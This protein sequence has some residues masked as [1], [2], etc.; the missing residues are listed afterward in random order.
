MT[1]TFQLPPEIFSE[2]DA[3]LFDAFVAP[4][5]LRFY[6]E[7]VQ[8]VLLVGQAAR[9]VHLGCRTGYPDG[10][11]L[12]LMPNTTGVGVDH[13]TNLLQLARGKQLGPGVEYLEGNSFQTGLPAA[14]FSHALSLHPLGGVQGRLYLFSEMARLLYAGG[15]AIV[16]LPLGR[17]FQE[18]T[19]LLA[20]Y[21]LKQD[22][23]QLSHALDAYALERVTVETLAEELES[24]GLSDVDF[25][26]ASYSLGYDSG[27]ALFED[28][29][30]RFLIAPH[31]SQLLGQADLQAAFDYVARAIDKY[32]SEERFELSLQ[33]AALSARRV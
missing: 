16:A 18:M 2:N 15:Q 21:A 23:L 3:A 27:R 6:W 25:E 13:S 32:W 20:E 30:V 19:D 14:T 5:Y 24:V 7:A 8:K 11:L 1:S 4:S 12:R 22:D 31:L 28:P 29:S 26:V 9:F 17:S 10:E 33:V